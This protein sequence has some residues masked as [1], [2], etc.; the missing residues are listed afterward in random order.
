MTATPEPASRAQAAGGGGVITVRRPD[1]RLPAG[2]GML[3]GMLIVLRHFVKSF[4]T[5]GATKR[6]HEG[7]FTV[8][9]P[10]ERL[11]VPETFRNMPILLYDDATG[12]ELCTACFQCERICPPKVIHITQARD[13]QTGK[14]VPAAEEF[15]IEYDS[16]MSCGYCH[17][18]CPFDAIKMDHFYE[19][20]T[21]DHLSMDVRKAE[22]NRPISY[23]RA[24]APELWAEVET[25][26]MKKLQ[27]NIKRRPGTI[28]IAPQMLARQLAAAPAASPASA[29]PGPSAATGAQQPGDKAQRLEAIRAANAARRAAAAPAGE[30]GT[31]LAESQAAAAGPPPAAPGKSMSPEKLARL[32]AI[33]AAKR[34]QQGTAASAAVPPTPPAPDEAA[35]A[36][37]PGGE[38]GGGPSSPPAAPGKNMSP[39]KLARLEAIRAAKRAQRENQ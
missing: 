37:A 22:L 6:Q 30:P 33:R 17:E 1:G 9:Y 7:M 16:C 11:A 10:E 31:Q 3:Q 27:N 19:L 23:Y 26:A 36:A 28:G 21:A 14:P 32:E 13:P 24:I 35:S 20:S 8:E 5:Y 39:E 25:Q 2:Q 29:A 4:T 38:S 34:A 12:H 15:V 18:V